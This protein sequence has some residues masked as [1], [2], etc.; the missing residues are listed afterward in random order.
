MFRSSVN[1]LTVF[2]LFLLSNCMK[3]QFS[4][5]RVRPKLTPHLIIIMDT[6]WP[7]PGSKL[8]YKLVPAYLKAQ[9]VHV[10][11][12]GLHQGF[13][14]FPLF[15]PLSLPICQKTSKREK[16]KGKSYRYRKHAPPPIIEE[17][18]TYKYS[19]S[20]YVIFTVKSLVLGTLKVCIKDEK[21]EVE[22]GSIPFPTPIY[23]FGWVHTPLEW[24]GRVDEPLENY[25]G[26]DWLLPPALAGSWNIS[27]LRR[28]A[29]GAR[30]GR[31][32]GG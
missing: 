5:C 10:Y 22:T 9:T 27:P 1:F 21:N 7:L 28:V 16:K 4:I 3:N 19:C 13:P 26:L 6:D 32:S 20:F 25:T 15:A 12:S 30:A 31:M 8:V 17:T 18:P 2:F 23:H 11:V 14:L 29:M 24:Y